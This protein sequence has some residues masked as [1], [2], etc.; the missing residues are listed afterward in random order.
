[1]HANNANEEQLTDL[2]E[3]YNSKYKCALRRPLVVEPSSLLRTEL[4]AANGQKLLGTRFT[5]PLELS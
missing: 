3:M 4:T 2:Y 1:M 5:W